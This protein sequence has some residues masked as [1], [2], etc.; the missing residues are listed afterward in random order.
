MWAILPEGTIVRYEWALRALI[1]D[2]RLG[3]DARRPYR[4]PLA[5]THREGPEMLEAKAALAPYRGRSGRRATTDSALT[6]N[7]S[8][9]RREGF[10]VIIIVIAVVAKLLKGR[11]A[12]TQLNELVFQAFPRS[13]DQGLLII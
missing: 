7:L 5:T 11:S 4:K 9:L 3:V 12:D 6:L 1:A 10:A 13:R 8:K 2:S